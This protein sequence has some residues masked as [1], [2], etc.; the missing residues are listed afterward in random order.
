MR[1]SPNQKNQCVT[2]GLAGITQEENGPKE[3]QLT[4]NIWDKTIKK[5]PKKTPPK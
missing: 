5:F 1:L 2:L 3:L 4:M